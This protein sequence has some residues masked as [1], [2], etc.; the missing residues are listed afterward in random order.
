MSENGLLILLILPLLLIQVSLAVYSILSIQ[1]KGVRSLTKPLW[2]AI[3]LLGGIIGSICFI[4]YGKK[5][6]ED[7]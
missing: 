3:S 2:L 5:G 4:I 6:D 1:N 7:D